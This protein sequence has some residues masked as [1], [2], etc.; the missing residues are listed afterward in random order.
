[1]TVAGGK[2]AT[3]RIGAGYACSATGTTTLTDSAPSAASLTPSVT[4]GSP[5]GDDAAKE[6]FAQLVAIIRSGR[7]TGIGRFIFPVE[8]VQPHA[9]F[10]YPGHRT[11]AKWLGGKRT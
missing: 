7:A 4:T 5:K 11:C 8:S 3:S 9:K 10:P 1:M 2:S 6:Q